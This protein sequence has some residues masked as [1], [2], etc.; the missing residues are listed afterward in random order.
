METLLIEGPTFEYA[1]DY[2]AAILDNVT[3][4]IMLSEV[5]FPTQNP[6]QDAMA[7]PRYAYKERN[8][9]ELSLMA[10]LNN[11]TS[12]EREVVTYS[13][14]WHGYLAIL[15]PFFSLFDFS[16]SRMFHLQDIGH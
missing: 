12:V 7:V 5:V 15:K 16:D 3:D 8:S 14:Y 9:P 13:R 2:K 1:Q 6:I 11:D 10:Y 4:A